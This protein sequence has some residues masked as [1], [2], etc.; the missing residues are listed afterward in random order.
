[1]NEFFLKMNFF[2]VYFWR[3]YGYEGSMIILNI[4][5]SK[6]CFIY[7]KRVEYKSKCFCFS[8]FF[9]WVVLDVTYLTVK[10]IRIIFSVI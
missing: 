2:F 8:L 10:M 1:M 3:I 6:Y 5:L 4:G 9:M 7:L